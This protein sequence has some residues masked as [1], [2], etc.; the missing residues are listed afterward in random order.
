MHHG[1]T[2][3]IIISKSD[4]MGVLMVTLSNGNTFRVTGHL[5]GIHRSPVNSP[6]KGP[7]T[8]SFDGFFDLRLNK[9]M[10]KQS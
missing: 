2:I 9:R 10:S 8:R 6:H 7:V 3:A 4:E 1:S 5:R